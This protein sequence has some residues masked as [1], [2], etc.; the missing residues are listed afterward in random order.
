MKLDFHRALLLYFLSLKLKFNNTAL[1]V[2]GVCLYCVSLL[3]STYYG[4]AADNECLMVMNQVLSIVMPS[5]AH[6][7]FSA[8]I[9]FVIGKII[10]ENQHRAK[11]R[12][13]SDGLQGWSHL[14]RTQQRPPLHAHDRAGQR[15]VR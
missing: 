9:F 5:P 6:S 7:F 1:I 10:A 12:S 2:V 14:S 3:N 13:C 4:F 15:G 11:L 8:F